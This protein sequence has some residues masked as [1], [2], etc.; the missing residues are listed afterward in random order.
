MY[1]SNF[2]FGRLLPST[3]ISRQLKFE[4]NIKF[5]LNSAQYVIY[6][7]ATVQNER[8]IINF[9]KCRMCHSASDLATE[10]R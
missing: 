5:Y 8:R 6:P 10:G 7:S 1:C 3:S 2:A 9:A 4:Q